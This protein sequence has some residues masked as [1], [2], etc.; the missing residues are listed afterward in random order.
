MLSGHACRYTSSSSSLV[1]ALETLTWH[2][3]A[4]YSVRLHSGSSCCDNR[5]RGHALQ[6]SSCSRC[7]FCMCDLV[8]DRVCRTCRSMDAVPVVAERSRAIQYVTAAMSSSQY[9]LGLSSCGG[10][11]HTVHSSLQTALQLSQRWQIQLATRLA[12]PLIP[13]DQS[14]T[15]L[16]AQTQA[17]QQ[18][19]G[20]STV[21]Q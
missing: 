2:V 8:C 3:A 9:F 15:R 18:P 12:E 13:S 20:A 5:R 7:T 4:L 19:S 17:A 21:Q 6:C 11:Q 14:S 16:I 1:A 10:P